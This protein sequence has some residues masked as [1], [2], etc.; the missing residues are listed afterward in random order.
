LP[1][2]HDES[3]E[4]K[5]RMEATLEPSGEPNSESQHTHISVMPDEVIEWLA[6]E[7]GQTIIDGTC[8]AGG[9]SILIARRLGPT[10]RVIGLDRDTQMLDLARNR[11][12][13]EDA[14]IIFRQSSYADAGSVCQELG[15]KSVNGLLVDL[16]LSSDQ[17]AWTDR[18]FSFQHDGPLDMRFDTSG[19][20]PTAAEIVNEWTETELADIFYHYGEERHSRRLARAVVNE[21]RSGPIQTTAQLA[22]L[23]RRAMPGPRGRIDP[24]T[25]VFQGLRIAV[26][27]ELGELERLLEH[28]HEWIAPGGRF[29]LISFHSLEDR[30]IKHRLREM[31]Q[32]E[33]LTRKVVTATDAELA[34]NPRSRSAK[35]RAYKR[36]EVI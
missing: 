7:P 16:G 17:L 18:G 26:N 12:R 14:S 34:V 10:G 6:L 36:T 8:G 24:A 29:V 22:D 3:P 5:K 20:R 35:L 13:H 31:P 4:I 2:C 27:D 25:R 33:V 21:R 32:W 9:H 28:A 19:D 1:I 30:M 11:A 23:I 15:L